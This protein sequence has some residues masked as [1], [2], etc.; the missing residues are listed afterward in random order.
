MIVL[1]DVIKH[2]QKRG[3][4]TT[5]WIGLIKG[6]SES[7]NVSIHLSNKRTRYL[8]VFSKADVFLSSFY[9][10]NLYPG[11]KNILVIHDVLRE[12]YFNSK[13]T[14][15][16][17]V[18]I[19]LM[20]LYVDKIVFISENT[21]DSFWQVY[22]RTKTNKSIV[23]HHGFKF[24]TLDTNSVVKNGRL[25]YVGKRGSY[26]NFEGGL[27]Y[28]QGL[29]LDIVGP[30][31][32]FREKRILGLYNITF[33]ELGYIGNVE[34]QQVYRESSFLYWPSLDEGFGLPPIEAI[35]YGCIPLC[36]RNAINIEIFGEHLLV[37]EDGWEKKSK[38]IVANEV[39]QELSTRFCY[40]QMITKYKNLLTDE[41][42]SNNGLL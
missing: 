31:L 36:T 30:P 4:I 3:G 42:N 33:Q 20:V 35:Q 26:K 10:V 2:I 13:K 5:W 28:I 37:L 1:D 12:R 9:R 15:L 6:L 38:L 40:D 41:I 19:Q 32:S 16:W 11:C 8:P 29:Y 21:R 27:K 18:Y 22:R 34:L 14:W 24:K 7:V 23:I 39:I 25:L 17:K